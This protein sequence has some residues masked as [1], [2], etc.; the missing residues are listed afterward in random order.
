ML[1]IRA[2]RA[3][4]DIGSCEKYAIGHENV[5]KSYGITKVTSANYEWFYNPEVYVI[6]VEDGDE[7][8]GGARIHGSGGNQPLPIEEAIGYMDPSIYELV[9]N[10]KKEKTGELC[11]LWNS[12]AIAGK[13]LSVILTKACVAKVGVAIA[14][15]LELRSLFVLCAPYTVKMVEEVGFEIITSLG[16][17]GTFPYPKDDMIATALMIRDVAGLTKADRDKRDDIF[18]LRHIPR[19]VRKEQGTQG[20]LDIEYDLYIPHLDEEKEGF[21]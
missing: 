1:K 21:S 9:R 11:G 10:F 12:R 14:N 19:Q 13:G 18:N 8:L 17:E 7:V 3:I 5:L 15:V 20:L 16:E 2:Y 6:A 4:D